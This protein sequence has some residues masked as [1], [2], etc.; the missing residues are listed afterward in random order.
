MIN[1]RTL[2]EAVRLEFPHDMFGNG[3]AMM[4]IL[5]NVLCVSQV[6]LSIGKYLLDRDYQLLRVLTL[7]LPHEKHK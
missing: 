6:A 4:N 5:S 2:V 3:K 7:S 1:I